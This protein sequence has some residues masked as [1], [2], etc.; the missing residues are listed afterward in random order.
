[1]TTEKLFAKLLNPFINFVLYASYIVFILSLLLQD[2]TIVR[3]A[4]LLMLLALIFH[5]VTLPVE[6]DATNI[7]KDNL[8]KLKI[9][10]KHELD[11]AKTLFKVMPY[12][13]LMTILTCI[14]NLFNE[15]IYNL[16]K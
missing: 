11:G 1:M 6:V 5:F 16:K 15:L 3:I 14:S 8:N 4:S 13:F 2:F 9:L 10:D 12:M 7:A